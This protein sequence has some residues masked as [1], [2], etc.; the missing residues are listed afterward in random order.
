[1]SSHT[2][3]K[4]EARACALRLIKFRPRS[5]REI[6]DKLALKNYAGPVIEETIGFLKRSR[7]IDDDMFARAW[8]EGRVR[9]PLGRERLRRELEA[10]GVSRQHIEAALEDAF[11]NIDEKEVVRGLIRHRMEQ[12]TGLESE[13]VKA[14]LFGYLV[15]RGYP[16]HLVI[17]TIIETVSK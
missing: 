14:R 15:R 4:K 8:V 16:Q 13:Q 5:E 17:E 1:M 12:M 3:E 10:K 11:K 2:D 6:R 9:R 7:L